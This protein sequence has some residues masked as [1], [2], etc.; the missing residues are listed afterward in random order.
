MH[1]CK[2]VNIICQSSKNCLL[3]CH[4][5]EKWVLT[6]VREEITIEYLDLIIF[7]IRIITPKYTKTWLYTL[8]KV[9]KK[10]IAGTKLTNKAV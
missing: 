4:L 9:F 3:T 5:E 7:E 6:N 10:S 2:M 1:K 8:V